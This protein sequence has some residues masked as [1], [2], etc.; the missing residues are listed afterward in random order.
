[1][2][3][4]GTTLLVSDTKAEAPNIMWGSKWEICQNEEKSRDDQPV[5]M[6]RSSYCCPSHRILCNFRSVEVRLLL[7]LYSEG[8]PKLHKTAPEVICKLGENGHF[9]C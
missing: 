2:P 8:D 5:S 9:H 7:Y 4:C 6:L 1:M 3:Q